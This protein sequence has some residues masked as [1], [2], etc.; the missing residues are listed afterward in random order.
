[1][2]RAYSVRARNAK[3]GGTLG[4]PPAHPHDPLSAAR[5]LDPGERRGRCSLE[6]VAA[7]EPV[8]EADAVG[9]AGVA[10]AA[11]GAMAVHADRDLP[12]VLAAGLAVGLVRQRLALGSRLALVDRA[13][14]AG[15]AAVLAARDLALGAVGRLDGAGDRAG[16]RAQGVR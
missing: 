3:T 4:S 10:V 5:W 2:P 8:L 11:V 15:E 13:A 1:M 6:I 7:V 16:A 12:A 14:R 9:V